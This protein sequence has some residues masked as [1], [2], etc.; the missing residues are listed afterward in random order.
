[1]DGRKREYLE[2]SEGELKDPMLGSIG[3]RVNRFLLA[4]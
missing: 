1:M 2:E 4:G 3:T